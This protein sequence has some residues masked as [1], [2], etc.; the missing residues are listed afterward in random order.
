MGSQLFTL[1]PLLGIVLLSGNVSF[2]PS[3]KSIVSFYQYLQQLKLFHVQLQTIAT[4][5][6]QQV[7]FSRST[8]LYFEFL[9]Q[10]C[11]KSASNNHAT[12]YVLC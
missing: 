6:P 10:I 5:C 3:A 7:E 4:I 2:C 11:L 12:G 9:L 8:I 1:D